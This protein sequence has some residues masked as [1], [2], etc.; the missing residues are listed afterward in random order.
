MNQA[1]EEVVELLPEPLVQR[2]GPEASLL[3]QQASLLDPA[4]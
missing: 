1:P 3:I 4:A 2:P